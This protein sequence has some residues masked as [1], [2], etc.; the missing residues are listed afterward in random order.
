VNKP[1]RVLFLVSL[2]ALGC[3]GYLTGQEESQLPV[4]HPECS[5]FGA[6][7]AKFTAAALQKLG[8]S[9]RLSQLTEQVVHSMAAVPGGSQTYTFD[10]NH[11]TGSIDSYIWAD[12][13]KNSITPAPATTDWEF[14]RRVTLD[15]TGRIPTPDRVL[16]FV[17]DTSSDKRAKLIDEL[18]ATP[19]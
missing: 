7:R 1:R 9:H 17:A 4:E 5:F 6:D 8:G 15:L 12:F 19:Q 3:T 14:I 18:I 11:A 10:Q 13:Q 2:A 16:S